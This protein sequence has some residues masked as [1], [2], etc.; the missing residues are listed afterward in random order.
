M[1][2]ARL[3]GVRDI[4]LDQ[5]PVPV[6]GPGQ[7]LVRVTA[8]GLCGSDL[9]WYAEAGIGD[10]VLGRPLVLGH[11]FA[12]VI[13]GGPRDG[14]RVA[15]DPAMPCERCATCR[16]GWRN[17]CPTVRF[18][19]HGD[20]DGGLREYLPWPTALLVPLPPELSD[21]D[22]A[23][24]EPLGVALHAAGLAR[25]RP[26][27]T[28]AVLGCGPIGLLLIQLARAAGA[29]AVLG[30]DPLAHRRAAAERAGADV[31]WDPAGSPPAAV[32]EPAVG[33]ARAALGPAATPGVDV[34]F[35]VAGTDD[36]VHAAMVAARPGGK[37][38]LVG[39]PDADSTTFPASVARR[40]GLTILLSRRM[41]DTYPRAIRLAQRGA[42]DLAAVVSDTYPLT[43]IDAAFTAAASRTGLKVV[44]QP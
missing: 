32:G 31:V 41:N 28:V 30:T 13:D 2:L 29:A 5:E 7:S 17:L 11:E 23:V 40:K 42:V 27:M 22:G 10:A 33:L 9:H 37:V 20:V 3:H 38:M 26:G 19:G 8:V 14:E 15:V 1:R 4:R 43:G 21:V 34:A 36:A 25:L 6:P 35:E 24:L 16:T 12:G 18:A 44:V 39:I